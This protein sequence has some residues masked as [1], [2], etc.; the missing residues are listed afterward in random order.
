MRIDRDSRSIRR[1]K[2]A[3]G[4]TLLEII[5]A[6]FVLVLLVSGIF[7]IVGGTTQLTDEMSRA[8]ERDARRHSFAE[9][10]SRMLRNLPGGAQVRL[11]V[12]QEG[13]HY[14]GEIGLKNAPS[15]IGSLGANGIT[16]L[17]T[18]QMTDGYLRVILEMFSHDESAGG[19]LAN[20][21]ATKQSII[22][23]E[24]V[25]KC[26]WRFYN[27][28][29][30]EW[31]PVWNEKLSFGPVPLVDPVASPAPGGDPGQAPAPVSIGPSSSRPG[32]VELTLA[33][34]AEAPQRFVFWVPP[35]SKPGAF[36][37]APQ[38]PVQ[39]P[40]P[41]AEVPPPTPPR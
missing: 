22:L 41:P 39:N 6:M 13:N 12:K 14:L 9:F 7:G 1:G 8:H 19:G 27:P 25:A 11:R 29:S 16:L 26:E 2:G 40:S 31:E 10:C 35:A 28:L 4:F 33:I 5:L 20:K 38:N 30:R 3:P 17:R 24:G 36:S 21:E 23:L 34:G 18:E 15:P 37:P 32:L